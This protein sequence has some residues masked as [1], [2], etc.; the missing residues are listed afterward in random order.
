MENKRTYSWQ[1][2]IRI[3]KPSREKKK[4][5]LIGVSSSKSQDQCWSKKDQ[6]DVYAV[7]HVIL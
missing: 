7:M 6:I 2:Q 5:S 3:K 4:K 1:L